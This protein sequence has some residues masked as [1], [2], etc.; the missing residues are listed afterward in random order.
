MGVINNRVRSAFRI[1]K[2]IFGSPVHSAIFHGDGGPR[3]STKVTVLPMRN[4]G[5]EDLPTHLLVESDC[6][7]PKGNKDLRKV[8]GGA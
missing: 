2:F 3:P 6:P 5:F 8:G 4:Q 7:T 1:V